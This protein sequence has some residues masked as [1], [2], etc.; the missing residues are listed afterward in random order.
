[1]FCSSFFRI[2]IAYPHFDFAFSK[3]FTHDFELFFRLKS[4]SRVA[5]IRGR[6][7]TLWW[8]GEW[9]RLISKLENWVL[10]R[11]GYNK[12]Q[13]RQL[14]R[15]YQSMVD[16]RKSNLVTVTFRFSNN[17]T[18]EF[19]VKEFEK[20]V[21]THQPPSSVEISDHTC[22]ADRCLNSLDKM[23]KVLR[24]YERAFSKLPRRGP[25][26][27]SQI[28]DKHVDILNEEAIQNMFLKCYNV[29]PIESEI[30]TSKV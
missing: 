12:L 29:K 4:S 18:P 15:G 13:P 16:K 8:P 7:M 22:I 10:K 11:N 17:G 26:Y 1:M 24:Q 28:F 30:A 20:N 2:K 25:K 19:T 14:S 6:A 3:F 23:D 9:D 5:L 27:S 21:Y